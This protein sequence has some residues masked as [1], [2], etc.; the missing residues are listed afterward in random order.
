MTACLR[1]QSPQPVTVVVD[2]G[3][4]E[5]GRNISKRDRRRVARRE[6]NAAIVAAQT[7]GGEMPS[8]GA[9][10]LVGA[11]GRGSEQHGRT[12]SVARR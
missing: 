9:L 10:D 3:R 7:L 1:T 6:R 5:R 4:A 2:E 8:C 11:D 12:V